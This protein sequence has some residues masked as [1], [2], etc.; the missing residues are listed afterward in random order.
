MPATLFNVW[1]PYRAADGSLTFE[2]TQADTFGINVGTREFIDSSLRVLGAR[3]GPCTWEITSGR[4]LYFSSYA[5]DDE[6]RDRWTRTWRVRVVPATPF[7][8]RSNDLFDVPLS[9]SV[10]DTTWSA[11]DDDRCGHTAFVIV[12]FQGSRDRVAR[13]AERGIAQAGIPATPLEPAIRDVGPD[14]WQLQLVVREL[15]L[16]AG[17]APVEAMVAEF[18]ATGGA[19]NW[20]HRLTWPVVAPRPTP[21]DIGGLL[22]R[23]RKGPRNTSP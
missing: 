21:P 8:P 22:E 12:D 4:S 3:H 19:V 6:W 23:L 18:A 14:R 1:N 13:I 15:E 7:P 5:E 11:D 16:P 17:L 2:V 9:Q 20:L 10:G